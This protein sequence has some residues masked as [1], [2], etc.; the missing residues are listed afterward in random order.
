[1]IDHQSSEQTV[2]SVI[3]APEFPSIRVMKSVVLQPKIRKVRRLA[4]KAADAQSTA[5]R[6]RV[7]ARV[8]RVAFKK[9][10]KVFKQAKRTAREAFQEAKAAQWTLKVETAKLGK[11]SLPTAPLLKR[12][13]RP[14]VLLGAP[15]RISTASNRKSDPTADPGRA[16]KASVT[17]AGWKVAP[18]SGTRQPRTRTSRHTSGLSESSPG[19]AS[20]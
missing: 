4:A 8:A 9:A 10:K 11:G 15:V 13:Y 16:R 20:I 18:E 5:K 14:E 17:S 3:A 6:A 2:A 19:I 7:Q 12:R 1:V